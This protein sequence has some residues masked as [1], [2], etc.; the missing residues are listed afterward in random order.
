M[1]LEVKIHAAQTSIL[2]ALLFLP[3]AS[4]TGLSKPTGLSSDH[5]N[6]HISR[7][8]ELGLVHKVS[9]GRYALTTQGKEYAN[10]LDTDNNTIER[11]PKAAVII[12]LT[13]EYKGET[14][15]LFQQRRKNPY[16]GFWGLPSGKI[17]WGES[18]TETAARESFEETGLG[19][20]F[21]VASM[22]H[23]QVAE[24]ESGDIIEDKLFFVV[25]GENPQG[26][27]LTDFEGGHN[28]W[29][30]LSTVRRKEKKY[31]TLQTEIEL[32]SA[33]HWFFE[34]TVTYSNQDF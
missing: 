30:S 7:L 32:L 31:T 19:A 17:R 21:T 23:E 11:Q 14:Q 28:Q 15:Y 24:K 26:T 3:S 20:D 16:Y 8:L 25:R 1:S 4:Y 33:E 34:Q 27:L 9:R 29:L 22:Y 13:R 10:R 5:F 2:R 18:I 12:G 6:F